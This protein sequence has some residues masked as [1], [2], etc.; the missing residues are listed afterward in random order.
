MQFINSGYLYFLFALIIPVIIHFFNFRRYKTVYFS[1]VA[2]LKTLKKET[3]KVSK[4]KHLLVLLLR[5]MAMAAVIIA[6]ARPVIIE[7]ETSALSD[8]KL[9]TIYID[10]SFSMS[11]SKGSESTFYLAKKKAKSILKGYSPSTKFRV[12]TNSKNQ[13]NFKNYSEAVS[14]IDAVEINPKIKYLSDVVE[15]ARSA[16]V[17]DNSAEKILFVFSDFQKSTCDFESIEATKNLE[18]N[19]VPILSSQPNN[20]YIDSCWFENPVQ[21]LHSASK[22]WVRIRNSGEKSFEKLPLTLHVNG[23][24][25]SLSGFS[26]AG[27][28]FTDV[29]LTF[30]NYKSGYQMATLSITDN[31]VTFDNKLFFSFSL[32]SQYKVLSIFETEENSNFTKLFAIDSLISFQQQLRSKVVYSDISVN[33]VVILDGVEKLSSGLSMALKE[34]YNSGGTI[35]IYPPENGKIT[36][37]NK[38]IANIENISFQDYTEQKSSV[39]DVN[40]DHYLFENVFENDVQLNAFSDKKINLPKVFKHYSIKS[41]GNTVMRLVNQLPFF[42]HIPAKGNIYAFAA[43]GKESDLYHHALFVPIMHRIVVTSGNKQNLYH[44][45]GSN[46]FVEV[47]NI[48]LKSDK[49]FVRLSHINDD[50]EFVPITKH[51]NGKVYFKV[52]DAEVGHYKIFHQE[53]Q[54]GLFSLNYNRKESDFV[55]WDKN[56]IKKYIDTQSC[57]NAWFSDAEQANVG[58]DKF[59][60]SDSRS[61]WQYFLILGLI[62]LGLEVIILR[63]FSNSKM[64]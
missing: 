5:L 64:V 60:L 1:N 34:F 49:D 37:L 48:D 18:I 6:F 39:I 12:I 28:S 7:G 22:L 29:M 23:E 16:L 47:D 52:G 46:E 30:T 56:K 10:N 33:D 3:D 14:D 44:Y 2:L 27:N 43:N 42:T 31:P 62:F 51:L 58:V 35:V 9:V 50:F 40:T 17:D 63:F 45:I 8:N 54:K 59:F 41:N 36:E 32:Q 11:F 4:I 24:K 61:L 57:I 55:A 20:I 53:E 26:V 15:E 21:Q 38:N 19:F 25:K 13:R